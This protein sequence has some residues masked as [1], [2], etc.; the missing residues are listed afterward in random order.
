M[1]SPTVRRETVL[2]A[3]LVIPA[4]ACTML[5][6]G[7]AVYRRVS[8][9]SLLFGDPPPRTLIDAIE[10]GNQGIERAYEFIAAGQDPNRPILIGDDLTGGRPVMASPLMIAIAAKNRNVVQ[11]LLSFGADPTLPQNELSMCLARAVGNDAIL[12]ALE[13]HTK[14]ARQVT[15]PEGLA[16]Q[17]AP[18]AVLL[19]NA[20][21]PTR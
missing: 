10:R 17:P 3:A 21:L 12:S 15:C 11:M 6:S 8:P 20:A 2:A 9:T 19:G 4:L 5:V 18:L 14:G 16:N 7:I 1:T 13:P